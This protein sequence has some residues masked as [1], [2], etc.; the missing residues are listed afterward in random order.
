VDATG[1]PVRW[2]AAATAVLAIGLGELVASRRQRSIVDP[3]GRVVVD[4]VPLPVVEATVRFVATWDKP[5]LR[6]GIVAGAAAAAERGAASLRLGQA[7]SAGWSVLAATVGLGAYLAGRR[8]LAA[9]LDRLDASTPAIPVSEPLP[10]GTD[11]AEDWDGAAALFTPVEEFYATDVNLRPIAVDVTDWQLDVRGPG[12]TAGTLSHEDLL[13]LGLLERD[14]IL[15]CVHQRLGWDRL[16]NQRWA[17]VPI[18]DVLAAAG[19]D[20]PG[21]PEAWDLAMTAVDGYSQVLPLDRAL[22]DDA[23]VVLG[24]GGRALPA[25]HGFPARVM[26]PGVVGQYNGVKWLRE[27]AVTPREARTATWVAR[28]WPRETVVPPPM[29]RIDHPGE[30]RMPP[31]LPRR[32]EAVA[33]DPWIVG[34]AWAPAHGGVE[35]VDV[36]V[37]DGPWEPAELAR[38]IGPASWRR[39]R[40]RVQL[41]PGRHV[42][43]ARCVAADGTVQ[44]P[45]PS[46]PFP[47]GTTGH[48]TVSVRAR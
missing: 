46:P 30:V 23:W 43:A 18:S 40:H 36:R 22:A 28:G 35:R 12:G 7:R 11:G 34:T 37:D 24:M 6:A 13:A 4:R 27:L 38:S 17:G 41:T 44:D 47:D 1:S 26:T 29:A 10:A 19:V 32:P 25:A 39:W 9:A 3:V 21:D 5:L 45:V 15:I 42:V 16:G 14:A 33:L 48:H 2:D 31:K 8:E 20:V